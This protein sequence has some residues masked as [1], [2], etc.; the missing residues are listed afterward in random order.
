MTSEEV[1]KMIL[2]SLGTL[3]CLVIAIK[4]LD[5]DRHGLVEALTNERNDRISLIEESNRQCVADRIALH[6]ELKEQRNEI[7]GMLKSMII[8]RQET[9]RSHRVEP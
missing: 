4:W 7:K 6:Q 5:K 3:V 9:E 2:G 8:D 1:L